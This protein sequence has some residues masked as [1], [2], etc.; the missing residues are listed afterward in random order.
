M[1]VFFTKLSLMEFQVR[2][3]AL[4]CLFLVIDGFKWR[5]MEYLHKNTQL[6]LEFL[7]AL[8]KAQG[9]TLFLLLLFLF[10]ILLLMKLLY[11][12]SVIRHLEF[13]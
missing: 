3:L 5:W 4:F 8:F 2:Y 6:M 7:K 10:I 11:T 9:P 1:L 13:V 12:L